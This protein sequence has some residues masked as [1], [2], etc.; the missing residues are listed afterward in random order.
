MGFVSGTFR[1]GADI[2]YQKKPYT[3]FQA[4]RLLDFKQVVL[5]SKIFNPN[6]NYKEK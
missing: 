2:Q 1:V 5:G 3:L 4:K 6:K